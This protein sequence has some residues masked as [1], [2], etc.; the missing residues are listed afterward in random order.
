[1]SDQIETISTPLGIINGRDAI[2]LDKVE[3]LFS[4]HCL[5][6]SGEFNSALC[7]DTNDEE[8]FISY[9]IIFEEILIFDCQHLDY[10]KYEVELLSNFD[11]VNSS[12]WMKSFNVPAEYIHY[13]FATYD[14]LYQIISKRYKLILEESGK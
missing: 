2:Y 12:S 8:N 6:F 14:Y 7:S 10:C 3:E 11:K 4:P 5:S 9:Q 13:R 1:M